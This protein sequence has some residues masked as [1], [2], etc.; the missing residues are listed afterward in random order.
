LLSQSNDGV[1]VVGVVS[2]SAAARAGLRS[3]DEIRFVGDSRVRT[4]A[5]LTDTVG[6]NKPGTLVDLIIS[7]NGRRQVVTAAL[8]AREATDDDRPVEELA[9][10]A[11][12]STARGGVPAARGRTPDAPA[13]SSAAERERQMS[14]RMRAMERQVYRLQQDLNDVRYSHAT[15]AANSY[16]ANAW[17][18]RQQ[19]GEADDDPALFQ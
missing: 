19:R 11:G 10:P 9:G 13:A 7:R 16:D 2:G 14:L 17:W 4:I 12:G 3:G 18:A 1:L 8:G 15:H 6:N 5:E